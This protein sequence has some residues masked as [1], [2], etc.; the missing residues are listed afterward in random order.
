M[1]KKKTLS[2]ILGAFLTLMMLPLS[3]AKAAE[4]FSPTVK[5]V[6]YQQYLNGQQ[7]SL[8]E[9]SGTIISA[10]GKILT[11]AHVIMNDDLG[12]PMDAFLICVNEDSK[13][14]P[15]CR[16]TATLTKYDRTIDLAVLQ[17]NPTP[18]WGTNP[19]NF[20]NL[21]YDVNL[22]P[23]EGDP[24][25]VRGFS[26]SGG[27]TINTTQGQISGFETM[28]GFSYIK[29]DADIDAGN[30]GGTML[31]A[32]GNFIGIPSYVVSY[33]ETS[34]RVLSNA[35]V[36]K[37]MDQN[38]GQAATPNKAAEGNLFSSVGKAHQSNESK[39]ISYNTAPGFSAV[40]PEGWSFNDA[41]SNH[42][43]FIKNNGGGSYLEG[44]M[45][46]EGFKRD[47]TEE[48]RFEAI[49]NK[50]AHL[51]YGNQEVMTL[52]KNEAYKGYHFWEKGYYGDTH[53]IVVPYGYHELEITYYISNKETQVDETAI[54]TFL[55]S[56]DFSFPNQDNPTPSSTLNEEGYPFTMS[57]PTHWRIAKDNRPGTNLALAGTKENEVQSLDIYYSQIV[58]GDPIKTPED[59]LSYDLDY[60]VPYNADVTFQS[61]DLVVDGLKGWIYFYDVYLD[62]NSVRKVASATLLDPEFELYF[63]YA[64]SEANFDEGL[65]DFIYGL[66][67][68]KSKRYQNAAVWGDA[69]HIADQG[70]YQIPL[71][72]STT[73][74]TPTTEPGQIELSD[75]AGHRYEENIQHLVDLGV[76]NGNPDGTF[77]PEEPVN[78]AAAL[79]II[80]ESL[81]QLQQENGETPFVMPADFDLFSDMP[82]DVWYATYVA[83]GVQKKIVEGY[84]DGTFK[85]E[86]R[87]N[88]AET[89]KM[90]LLAY[91]VPVWSG[92]TEPWYKKYF[93]AAYKINLLPRGL[94]DPAHLVTRGELAYMV[95]QMVYY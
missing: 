75:I 26:A 55:S 24:V 45:V 8:M 72:K 92:A 27:T 79:K 41:S 84:A 14:P 50:L 12:V 71:P 31:D 59:G 33:Y 34:G 1:I 38:G 32:N 61:A 4:P 36:K 42:F 47:L 76:I 13:L 58:N 48:Q 6:S 89:L 63:D 57:L 93:D 87:V 78:R 81:R 19:G 49:K 2:I 20:P 80:L 83:E 86:N 10:D 37:W 65:K 69:I 39:Q 95:D 88:L 91:D 73:P 46:N 35:E 54:S 17:I 85:G 15:V 9:G 44:A 62:D 90:L 40:L 18:I 67:S 11:N 64:D 25:T 3:P 82:K 74:N 51:D 70:S 52:G 23:K 77:R 53:F 5:I 21:P 56:L 43:S 7:Q 68:F 94:E 66:K 60:Y 29:T 22:D 28:N 30:S 16:F